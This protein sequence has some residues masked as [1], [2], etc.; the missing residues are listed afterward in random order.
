MSLSFELYG[1]GFRVLGFMAYRVGTSGCSVDA[2]LK[3]GLR[4]LTR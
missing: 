4:A 3:V 2:E 1:L